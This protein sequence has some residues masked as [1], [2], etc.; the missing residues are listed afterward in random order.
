MYIVLIFLLSCDVQE[1]GSLG[2]AVG[3]NQWLSA[4]G[5]GHSGLRGNVC[6]VHKVYGTG[7]YHRQNFVVPRSFLRFFSRTIPVQVSSLF[8]R[9]VLNIF[10]ESMLISCITVVVLFLR[11]LLWCQNDKNILWMNQHRYCGAGPKFF[12]MFLFLLDPESTESSAPQHFILCPNLVL[13][14]RVW[15]IS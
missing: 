4:A 5:C 7:T 11:L 2:W 3:A 12:F 13:L 14:C 1:S 9:K 6:C 8:D 15:G 10:F